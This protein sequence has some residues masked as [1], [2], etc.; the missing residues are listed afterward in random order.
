MPVIIESRS[1]PGVLRVQLKAFADDRG[2][3]TEIF[4]KEW[5]PQRT[6]GS[7][8][9]N[10][11]D[12]RQGVLRGL[13]YHFRQVD[14]WYVISGTIRVGLADL[15]PSSPSY[16]CTET[17]DLD[18]AA[19]RGLYIPVG[20]AHGFLA[21]SD[22]TLMYI[23]DNYFDGSDE[24]GLAWNDPDIVVDWRATHSPSLSGRDAANPWFRDIP[25][26]SLPDQ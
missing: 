14:Y 16:R 20:V 17:I 2:R 5:F 26:A 7:I 12:S 8:Q 24:F 6:W 11:S 22:V 9:S 1:I 21:L 25:P 13:H 3:F 4:R 18:A 15:R 10:R 19:N 23:V